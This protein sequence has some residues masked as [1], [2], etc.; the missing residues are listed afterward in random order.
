MAGDKETKMNP[1]PE[2]SGSAEKARDFLWQV[3]LYITCK[4]DQFKDDTAR[5][6]WTLSFIRGGPGGVWAGEYIDALTIT[7]DPLSTTTPPTWAQFR[8]DFVNKFFPKNDT[9]EV[10]NK[11]KRLLQGRSLAQDYVT[12][13]NTLAAMTDY[14]EV[15]L[16]EAFKDGMM[17]SLKL[18]IMITRDTLATTLKEWQ[19]L[20]IHFDQNKRTNEYEISL[21]Q[22]KG[23]YL[24]PDSI[25]QEQDATQRDGAARWPRT[26][27]AGDLEIEGRTIGA[28]F[29]K[30]SEEE[31]EKRRK[32]GTCFKCN[33][34]GHYS[35]E[36][37]VARSFSNQENYWKDTGNRGP[38]M[39]QVR[40]I[41][42]R[43]FPENSGLVQLSRVF[44]SLTP[45]EWLD[46]RHL[47]NTGQDF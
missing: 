19:D 26:V 18:M 21:K 23:R 14:P 12:G 7:L 8:T 29:V 6:A 27:R 20:A 41:E 15:A 4:K 25:F 36:C 39:V 45:E 37:R 16:T 5:I 28:G 34:K 44:M 43:L 17:P 33:K 13:F 30:L 2:Y 46:I 38:N 10:R 3:D 40:G 22:G 1:P 9:Q 47:Y 42:N 24:Y 31:M 35:R 32:E 11:L